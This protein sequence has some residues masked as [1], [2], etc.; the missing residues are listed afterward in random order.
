MA[1]KLYFGIGG[2]K[3]REEAVKLYEE[4]AEQG[5]TKAMLAL[6][7]MYEEKGETAVAFENYDL[8]AQ[9]EPYAMFKLG[10]FMEKGLYNK[11]FRSKPSSVFALGL[12]K[13]AIQLNVGS[14]EALFKLGE[15]F[16]N[17]IEVERNVQLAIRR[18]EE[19]AA[20]GHVL[21][22]NALGSLYYNQL[23]DYD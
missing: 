21:A 23:K 4:S 8:A 20:E 9:S 17:G 2:S 1:D 11:E 22:M 6:A 12:Y 19:A 14:R 7:A 18:Y 3:N 16:Q 13:R 15:Y 10:E 5:C